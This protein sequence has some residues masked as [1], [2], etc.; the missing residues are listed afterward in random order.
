MGDD[1]EGSNMDVDGAA[2]SSSRPGPRVD[3][4]SLDH[5]Y[6]MGP[7]ATVKTRIHKL[8]RLCSGMDE[9]KL[10]R[11]K[12]DPMSVPFRRRAEAV[13]GWALDMLDVAHDE[14]IY[15]EP[16]VSKFILEKLC[17]N[18]HLHLNLKKTIDEL[19][20]ERAPG[21]TDGTERQ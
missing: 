10:D 3:G 13:L 16:E 2:S 6:S 19:V 11:D 1:G 7:Y 21:T 12:L 9:P 18:R 14:L 4:E 20:G 17:L 8:H 15:N 5:D